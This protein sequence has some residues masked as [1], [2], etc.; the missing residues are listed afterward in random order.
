[1]HAGYTNFLFVQLFQT[2]SCQQSLQLLQS[3]RLFFLAG[4]GIADTPRV[5]SKRVLC[6]CCGTAS[7]HSLLLFVCSLQDGGDDLNILFISRRPYT[8]F[9]EHRFMGRQVTNEK[10]LITALDKMPQVKAELVDFAQIT[11]QEQIKRVTES[12]IMVQHMSSSLHAVRDDA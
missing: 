3:F 4:I 11:F 7:S 1:M 9:V 8:K 12:D 6:P 10:E 2:G 5:S